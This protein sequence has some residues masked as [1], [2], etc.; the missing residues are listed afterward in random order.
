MYLL[1]VRFPYMQGVKTLCC[2]IKMGYILTE[3]W[4]L[5]HN[6]FWANGFWA[7]GFWTRRR[8]MHKWTPYMFLLPYLCIFS[9]FWVVPVSLSIVLSMGDITMETWQWNNFSHWITLFKDPLYWKTLKNT[10]FNYFY[11]SA[12]YDIFGNNIGKY[13]E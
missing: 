6:G 8:G 1:I 2:L 5:I 4:P 13:S 12:Y 3:Y 9:I 7:N 11:S 10:F